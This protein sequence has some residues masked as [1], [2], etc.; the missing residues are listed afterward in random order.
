MPPIN[1]CSLFRQNRVALCRP[2]GWICLWRRIGN[3]APLNRKA[4][5]FS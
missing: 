5:A 2:A 3:A 4:R 1:L